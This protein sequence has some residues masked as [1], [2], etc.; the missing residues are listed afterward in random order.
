MKI[1]HTGQPGRPCKQPNLTLLQT[2]MAPG[3]HIS[4]SKLA[5]LIGIHHNTLHGY[6]KRY[7]IDYQPTSISNNDLNLLV[8]HFHTIKSQSGLQYLSGSMRHHGLR[9]QQ[10]CIA[11][12]LHCVDP[13]GRVLWWCT[14]ICCCQYKVSHPNALCMD[15]HHKLIH[16][17]I[18]IHGVIDGYCQTVSI[19]LIYNFIYISALSMQSRLLH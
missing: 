1:I 6:L 15:G 3:C 5:W 10:Q 2:A 12:S 17:D 7:N 8:Q 11:E 13:L 16:W 9:I 19:R 14:T 18:I 4:V